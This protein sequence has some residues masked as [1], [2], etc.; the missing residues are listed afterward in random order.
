MQATIFDTFP[1]S[2]LSPPGHQNAFPPA[3]PQRR[4]RVADPQAG[5]L[6]ILHARAHLPPALR[7]ELETDR[8]WRRRRRR[9]NRGCKSGSNLNIFTFHF[10]VSYSSRRWQRRRADREVAG[11]SVFW[12]GNIMLKWRNNRAS[13]IADWF[14]GGLSVLAMAMAF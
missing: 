9:C 6:P 12:Y 14:G 3:A 7:S 11:A 2:I 5:L 4:S 10:A 8:H 13:A 1:L